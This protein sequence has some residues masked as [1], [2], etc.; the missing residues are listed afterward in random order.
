MKHV[1]S[2]IPPTTLLLDGACCFLRRQGALK[3]ERLTTMAGCES[4]GESQRNTVPPDP[5]D[6]DQLSGNTE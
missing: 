5:G 1:P 3:G 2:Q 6:T 4:V